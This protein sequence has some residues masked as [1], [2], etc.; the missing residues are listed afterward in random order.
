MIKPLLLVI[1]LAVFLSISCS[2]KTDESPELIARS[3]FLLHQG[4][5][6]LRQNEFDFAL[7]LAD[8]AKKL[9]PQSSNVYF[10]YARIYSELGQWQ[11][12]EAAYRQVLK[13][14][15][16]YRGVWNNLGNNAYRQQEYRRAIGYYQK[17]LAINPAAIPWRG[18]GRAYVELGKVDSAAYAFQ[19]AIARDSLYAPAHFSLALLLEDEGE[20][21]KALW[22]ARKASQIEKDNLEYRYLVG[23]LLV[24]SRKYEEAL[25]LLRE[26]VD[27]MPWYRGAQYNYGQALANLGR[28]E[29]AKKYLDEA[30]RVRAEDAK[31][32][33]LQN[34]IRSLPNDPMAHATLAFALRRVGRYNDAM[35]AYKVAAYLAPSNMDIQNNIANLYLIKGDTT[36]AINQYQMILRHD[37]S[38]VDIWMNLGVVYAISKN[39]A[40]ARHAWQKALQLAPDHPAAKAYLARLPNTPQLN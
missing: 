24:R 40:A 17:E 7:M 18:M 35:H 39:F 5:T 4:E 11:K 21:D 34:T 36:A 12:A 23:E 10:L 27:K 32:E 38:L 28:Q 6:A 2:S 1:H 29:E 22:H 33:H 13:L 25:A 19:N 9:T 20:I 26:V 14:E 15:P 16:S 8:S 3:E 37:P 31:I 30:E